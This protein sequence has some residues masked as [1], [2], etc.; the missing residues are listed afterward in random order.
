[1]A[2]AVGVGY[3]AQTEANR[4]GVRPGPNVVYLRLIRCF[5][6]EQQETSMFTEMTPGH[7]MKLIRELEAAVRVAIGARS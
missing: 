2:E 7:A 1:M 3:L 6:A 5:A 4:V